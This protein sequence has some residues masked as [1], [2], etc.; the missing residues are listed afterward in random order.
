MKRELISPPVVGPVSITDVKQWSVIEGS[1]DDNLIAMLIV[2]AT[3]YAEDYMRRQI[4]PQT[5]TYYFDSFD[6]IICINASPVVSVSIK[7]DDA[8]DAEQ[9][10]DSAEYYADTKAYPVAITAVSSWPTTK[11]KPNAVRVSL[12][13]GYADANSVPE[14]IKAGVL[15]LIGHFYEDREGAAE[16]PGSAHMM[17]D[18]YRIAF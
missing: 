12:V 4:M 16:I 1:D 7:Y 5:W 15:L 2:R 17:L 18:K 11:A 6:P 10:L 8:D 14:S 3:N 13:C 9:T